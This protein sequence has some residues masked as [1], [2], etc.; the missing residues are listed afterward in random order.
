M[1][2]E[3]D[4]AIHRARMK[5]ASD[6]SSCC[7]NLFNEFTFEDLTN[8]KPPGRKGGKKGKGVYVIQ[9]KSR[10]SEA[11][12]VIV[13]KVKQLV[14]GLKWKLVEDYVMSRIGR[15]IKIGP[16]P[17][18]YIGSAGTQQQSKNTLKHRYA[19]LASRH[20][21]MYPIWALLY[22][23]WKLKYGWKECENPLVEEERI[24]KRY[25]DLHQGKSP[26]LVEK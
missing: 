24:K 17:V 26:A 7:L 15:L 23:G 19:E 5:S 2:K 22:F 13:R 21:A 25:K 16:C 9:I 4:E 8:A 20:T 14:S 12:E 11:P 1:S 3:I 10:A 6:R 18:I